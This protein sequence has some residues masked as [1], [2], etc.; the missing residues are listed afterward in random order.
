MPT[1]RSFTFVNRRGEHDC[2]A[3][4]QENGYEH[5]GHTNRGREQNGG[6]GIVLER[7]HYE[8]ISNGA[9]RE[10]SGMFLVRRA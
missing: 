10:E 8:D 7:K 1:D 2:P 4:D 6:P 3:D 9:Q 5:A